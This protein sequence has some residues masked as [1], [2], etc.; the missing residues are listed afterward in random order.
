MVTI[1]RRVLSIC[2]LLMGTSIKYD[3]RRALYENELLASVV[4]VQRGHELVLRFEWNGV[5]PGICGLLGLPVHTE[6]GREW[7]ERPLGRIAL[8]LPCPLLLEQLGVVTE[9]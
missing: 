8:Y 1:Q 5:D 9:H 3:L 2:G 6:L 7:V 4:L